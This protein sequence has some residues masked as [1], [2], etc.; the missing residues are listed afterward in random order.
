MRSCKLT[1]KF[2]TT[3]PKDIRL[4]LNLKAGD[5]VNFV[6]QDNGHVEVNKAREIEHQVQQKSQDK[7][8][9]AV[10]AALSPKDNH[11]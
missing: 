5:R 7:Q 1:T 2:Q 9:H 11:H 3:I 6:V 4:K 8:E 10:R